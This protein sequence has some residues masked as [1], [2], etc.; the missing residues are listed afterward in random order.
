MKDYVLQLESN[1]IGLAIQDNVNIE[2]KESEVLAPNRQLRYLW[3]K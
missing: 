3:R 2:N 1:I